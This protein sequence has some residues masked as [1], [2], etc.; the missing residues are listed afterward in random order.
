MTISNLVDRAA[1]A[2]KDHEVGN[3]AKAEQAYRKILEERQDYPAILHNL[4]VLLINTSRIN[5]GIECFR[6]TVF[7]DPEYEPA[8]WSL[9][10]ALQ[11]SQRNDE[12]IK[13]LKKVITINPEHYNAQLALGRLYLE[14]GQRDR[15]LDFFARTMDLR[16]GDNRAGVADYSLVET[17]KAKVF[18]DIE[19]F[20]YLASNKRNNERLLSLARAYEVVIKSIKWP[21]NDH[22]AISLENEQL[23]VFG[24]TYNYP[25]FVDD[26]AEVPVSALNN[27]V[28]SEAI[29]KSFK[30]TTPGVAWFDNFLTSEALSRLTQ[31]LLNSTIWFDFGHIPG[32][33]AAY[34]EDGLASPLLLQI[35]DN[36]REKLPEILG[37][38]PLTQAWAFKGLSENKTIELH[39]DDAAVSLNFWI[40][41]D[42]ANLRH[43]RSG[44]QVYTKPPPDNWAIRNYEEDQ[45]EIRSFLKGNED[46]KIIIPYRQNRAVLF[47]SSFFHGSDFPLFATGYENHRINI[48]LLFG[49]KL[50]VNPL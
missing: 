21:T 24:G 14:L 50:S 4:G 49:Q 7:F 34:L 17:T 1:L 39:A 15:A 47:D 26:A 16:R 18:H 9:A 13:A 40:T 31:Y 2:L 48:T 12:A 46:Q 32:F 28:S 33:L 42:E 19:Q 25:N 11:Q 27:D 38:H 30:E 37:N 23:E 43:G 45:K 35:A 3:L 8:Y 5:E 10:K 44:L 20:R 6:K 41:S 22:E 36:L 29:Y